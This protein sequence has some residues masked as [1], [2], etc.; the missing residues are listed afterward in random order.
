MKKNQE[1]RRLAIFQPNKKGI[2]SLRTN[3]N[4]EGSQ[5]VGL[6]KWKLEALE[7]ERTKTS[8]LGP[9]K[10]GKSTRGF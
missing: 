1:G 5:K 9:P 6:K 10:T 4:R 2:S 7:K 3:D 8:L